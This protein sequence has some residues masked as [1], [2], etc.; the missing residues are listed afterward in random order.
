M[1]HLFWL[2]AICF[3]ERAF[4]SAAELRLW[5]SPGHR[6]RRMGLGMQSDVGAPMCH[7]HPHTHWCPP[8]P[9]ACHTAARGTCQAEL[10]MCWQL[11]HCPARRCWQG[12]ALRVPTAG[13]AER[14]CCVERQPWGAGLEGS[15]LPQRR[16]K[17]QPEG[18]DPGLPD[19]CSSLC[20]ITR[21][22]CQSFQK[23]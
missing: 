18:C 22:N 8:V 4:L 19:C 5:C 12:P 1:S 15:A 21:T 14:A 7:R 23:V 2:L 9:R 13:C 20:P 16:G 3:Q 17:E 10:G 11:V 6:G